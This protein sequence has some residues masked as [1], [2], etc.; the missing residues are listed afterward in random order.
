MGYTP[1]RW[2]L[3]IFVVVPECCLSLGPCDR[4]PKPASLWLPR[5]AW[6]GAYL[7][8]NPRLGVPLIGDGFNRTLDLDGF[9]NNV[10][11]DSSQFTPVQDAGPEWRAIPKDAGAAGIFARFDDANCPLSGIAVRKTPAG[12]FEA[13]IR[14][15]FLGC[16]AALG[17]PP[18]ANPGLGLAGGDAAVVAG[19]KKVAGAESGIN[20]PN[21]MTAVV[22][23]PTPAPDVATVQLKTEAKLFMV[24][25]GTCKQSSSGIGE[26]VPQVTTKELCESEC[27][28]RL[29]QGSIMG[30]QDNCTGFAFSASAALNQNCKVYKGFKVE[31]SNTDPGWGCYSMAMTDQDYDKDKATVDDTYAPMVQMRLRE[32]M[33][34]TPVSMSTAKLYELR[35][36]ADCCPTQSCFNKNFWFMLQDEFGNEAALPVFEGDWAKM[37]DMVPNITQSAFQDPIPDA[38]VTMDLVLV[39]TCKAEPASWGRDCIMPEVVGTCDAPH[40]FTSIATGFAAPFF[41]WAMVYV[42][43]TNLPGSCMKKGTSQSRDFDEP[44]KGILPGCLLPGLVALCLVAVIAC[45]LSAVLVSTAVSFVLRS[46]QCLHGTRE[47]AVIGCAAGIPGAIAIV[48]GL[49]Y[50]YCSGK[51]H[52]EEPIIEEP[53][54][55]VMVPEHAVKEEHAHLY[56][57]NSPIAS[58]ASSSPQQRSGE[59]PLPP[60]AAS[61]FSSFFSGRGGS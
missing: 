17:A 36:Q 15:E 8:G 14:F 51:K 42:F 9:C 37:M 7:A 47:M 4:V 11:Y 13:Q 19:L 61:P 5:M 48:C 31:E 22:N 23:K 38:Q 39:S 1:L 44:D 46:D 57:G 53:K 45:G 10:L 29:I 26:F 52:T 54:R 25:N 28:T 60:P 50:I 58:Q 35:P 16:A 41:G 6:E 24:G 30:L 49:L 20:L 12:P 18:Q 55:M 56:T 34:G 21:W 32:A 3:L 27:K 2:S 59:P 43:A 33:A 40:I